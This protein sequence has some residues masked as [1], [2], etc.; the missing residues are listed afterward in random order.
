MEAERARRQRLAVLSAFVAVVA[1]VVL[2]AITARTVDEQPSSARADDGV[3][4][5]AYEE[6]TALVAQQLVDPA[7]AT[8]PEY[9]QANISRTDETWVISS[10]VDAP[11]GLG[12]LIRSNWTCSLEATQRGWRGTATLTQ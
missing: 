11:N 4:V 10:Y 6:C 7:D 12:A 2:Y 1:V 5:G 8:F 3:D 9:G